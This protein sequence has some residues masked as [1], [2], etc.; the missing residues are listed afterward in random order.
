MVLVVVSLLFYSYCTFCVIY[1][2]YRY[3]DSESCLKIFD[4]LCRYLASTL[5]VLSYPHLVSRLLCHL[6]F[7]LSHLI[8]AFI[9]LP[10][11]ILHD[12]SCSAPDPQVVYCCFPCFCFIGVFCEFT[13]LILL[14]AGVSA[15]LSSE[16]VSFIYFLQNPVFLCLFLVKQLYLYC[17]N[18]IVCHDFSLFGKN[19]LSL[20]KLDQ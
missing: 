13:D 15:L 17:R 4:L 19:Q 10:V 5:D 3:F 14:F 8:L 18:A 2:I 12:F 6:L 7:S 11:L 1:S 20:F 16:F 9:L